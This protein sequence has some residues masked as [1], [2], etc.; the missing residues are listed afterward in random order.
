MHEN[1][2][3]LSNTMKS[4]YLYCGI[5]LFLLLQTSAW[6]QDGER[7]VVPLSQ[8]GQPG[9]LKVHL[10]TGSIEV[11]GY[12]GNEVIVDYTP[13][14]D[15]NNRKGNPPDGMRRIPN[16]NFGLRII[17]DDNEVEI[18]VDIPHKKTMI[19]VMVP[20]QFSLKLGTVNNGDITVTNTR[21]EMEI[22]NVN[23][24]IFMQNISG[25][26]IANTVNGDLTVSFDQ[27]AA[28]APMSFTTLNGKVDVT[29]PSTAK[30]TARMSTLNGEIYTDFDLTLN[31]QGAKVNQSQENGVLRIEIDKQVY[32]EINGG[33]AEMIFKSHNGDILIRKK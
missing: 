25:A 32:G 20:R 9:W 28:D 30:A 26:V 24:S 21:G 15:K 13:P 1:Y 29:L 31:N 3:E 7:V 8:P 16:D 27:I 22:S 17:E 6:A 10:V 4:L 23:G 12:E 11:N 33:G 14:E 2:K 5:A 19:Q 18:K